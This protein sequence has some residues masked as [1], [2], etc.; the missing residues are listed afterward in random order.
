MEKLNIEMNSLELNS[1][2]KKW[3]FGI[4]KNELFANFD[5]DNNAYGESLIK[6]GLYPFSF[7]KE[8]NVDI[9]NH[10]T[11]TTKLSAENVYDCSYYSQI[12]RIVSLPSVFIKVNYGKLIVN[13]NSKDI[14]LNKGDYQ[15]FYTN[16]YPMINCIDDAEI[17]ISVYDE[18]F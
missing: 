6:R 18:C 12:H 7:E 14:I 16:L 4:L 9:Q 15:T 8:V 17:I 2:K 11:F 1:F 3:K 5:D 13:Y 10:V